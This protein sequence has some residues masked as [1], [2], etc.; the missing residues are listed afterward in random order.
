MKPVRYFTSTP[1][2]LVSC[3]ITSSSFT[4]PFTRFS[5]SCITSP[6]GATRGR[7]AS[8]D[9]AESAAVVA[10]LGDLQVG[11]VPRRQPYPGSWH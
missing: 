2:A 7:R 8:K 11:I 9:D 4:P 10:A 6:M 1:Y 5:A 3:E